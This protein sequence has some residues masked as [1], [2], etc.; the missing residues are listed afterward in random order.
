MTKSGEKPVTL[1]QYHILLLEVVL[2]GLLTPSADVYSMG[3]TLYTLLTR[4]P[5]YD[6]R[7]F[8]QW[9]Q[10]AY[11]Q[12]GELRDDISVDTCTLVNRCLNKEPGNRFRDGSELLAEM[13]SQRLFEKFRLL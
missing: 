2:S 13:E 9:F 1:V 12:L 7:S 10:G 6:V 5:P 11:T 3:A 8:R 4:Q